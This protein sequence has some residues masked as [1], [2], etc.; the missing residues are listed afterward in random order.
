MST[1]L[2]QLAQLVQGRVRG[3]QDRPVRA[4]RSLATAGPD[5][6]S[7]LTSAKYRDEALTSRAGALLVG[8]EDPELPHDQLICADALGRWRAVAALPPAPPRRPASTRRQWWRRAR[9]WIRAPASVRRC[10][11]GGSRIEARAVLHAG[12]VGARCR[13]GVSTV[14][15]PRAVLYDDTELGARVIVHAG[16]VLGA[17][18]FGYA[19]HG[20]VLVKVPQV[21]RVV[22]EDDVEIGANST[23]DRATLEETRIGAGS[24][25]DN[26][27]Q[28]GHNV[29]LLKV[30]A[31]GQAGTPAAPAGRRGWWR[32]G[33]SGLPPR[34]RRRRAGGGEV[35]ALQSAG[36]H[37]LAGIPPC[38]RR[39]APA[40]ELARPAG[41][42]GRRCR[43]EKRKRKLTRE[44]KQRATPGQ[45]DGGDGED[46]R[47][48]RRR[49][50]SRG[51]GGLRNVSV[52]SSP[53]ARARAR[54]RI[55]AL[56]N[57]TVN[58]ESPRPLPG[59]PLGRRLCSRRW[60]RRAHL[61]SRPAR[62]PQKL[63]ISPASSAPAS[64]RWSRLPGAAGDRDS[65][66]AHQLCRLKAGAGGRKAGG[67]AVLSSPGC[68]I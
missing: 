10:G 58:E 54:Q 55:V 4:V 52:R 23:V 34:S 57:V 15:Y 31:C 2:G 53:R 33:V 11:G 17:D 21:G 3:N 1:T 19:P 22:V 6:L 63:P 35:G 28:V 61:L 32:G 41:E 47:S 48:R 24:K 60:R 67:R 5:D 49:W 59:H 8:R 45:H 62:P 25:L 20:G 9:R 46:V 39:L 68:K 44:R 7:L 51:S 29:R 56:K 43:L 27:V 14:V 40:G 37:Q 65:Q 64:R 42:L 26:L 13:V 18:G 30:R 12:G 16:A 36:G 66:P 38:A 50:D